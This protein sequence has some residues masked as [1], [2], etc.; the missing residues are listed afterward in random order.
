MR[1]TKKEIKY[2][3]IEVP[4]NKYDLFREIKNIVKNDNGKYLYFY[5]INGSNYISD[6]PRF[7]LELIEASNLYINSTSIIF[8]KDTPYYRRTIHKINGY[9]RHYLSYADKSFFDDVITEIIRICNTVYTKSNIS[10]GIY[11]NQHLYMTRSI[12]EAILILINRYESF[13]RNKRIYD[14]N[15]FMDTSNEIDQTILDKF[16]GELVHPNM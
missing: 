13:N 1:K 7:I 2:I 16:M 10:Y 3:T 14:I 6:I 4:K 5:N 8:L 9:K 11:S 15:T 12:T